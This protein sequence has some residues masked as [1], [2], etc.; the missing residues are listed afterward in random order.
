[1]AVALAID[2]GERGDDVVGSVRDE[3]SVVV[4]PIKLLA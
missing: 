1:L 2:A 4:Y 3:G